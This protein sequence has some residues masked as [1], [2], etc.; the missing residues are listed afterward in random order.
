MVPLEV[1]DASPAASITLAMPKSMTSTRRALP[2]SMMFSGLM[3][4]CT[5]PASCAEPSAL[6]ASSRMRRASGTGRRPSRSRSCLRLSP[7]MSGIRM[8]MMPS[9]SPM[10]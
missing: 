6:E 10:S 9:A 5:T 1:S 4:R 7:L 2:S 3:S 8:Y